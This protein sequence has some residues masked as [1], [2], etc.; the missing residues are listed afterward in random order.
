ML[1]VLLV[2][3]IMPLVIGVCLDLLI[4]TSPWITICMGILSLPVSAFFVVR[5][6]RHEMDRVIEAVAPAPDAAALSSD[7]ASS[8][9]G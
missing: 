8:Q 9:Q 5:Q 2:T 1:F 7:S 4:E 3:L 6:G